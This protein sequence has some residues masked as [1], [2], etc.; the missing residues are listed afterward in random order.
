M[1]DRLCKLPLANEH[2]YFELISPTLFPDCFKY[3]SQDVGGTCPSLPLIYDSHGRVY[4]FID[5]Y[6]N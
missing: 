3:C 1:P 2:L 6:G 4:P 5:L